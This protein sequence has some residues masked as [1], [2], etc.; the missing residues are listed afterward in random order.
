MKRVLLHIAFWFVYL[1]QDVVLV[2]LVDASMLSPLPEKERII[3]AIRSCLIILLPK[4]LFTYFMLYVVLRKIGKDN[5]QTRKHIIYSII[6]LIA[7]LFLYRTMVRY[8]TY[9]VVYNWSK[10]LPTYFDGVGFLVALMDIGFASGAAIVIKLIRL[11]LAAKERERNLTKEKLEAE[12]KY[13]R[14]QTNPHFLFNTLNNIYALTRKKSDEAPEAVMKL[15]KLLRFMLYESRK[16]FIKIGDEMKMLDNYIELEKIR[17]NGRLTINFFREI[18]DENEQI[19]PLLLLPFVENYFKHGASE[20]RF[21]SYIHIDMRLQN[22]VLNFNV[23]NTKELRENNS[24]ESIGLNNVRRQLELMYKDYDMNVQ[25]EDSVF[26]V[27][28][29]INLKSH[30]KI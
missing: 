1:F 14:N 8:F 17:Y 5:S 27:S 4:L 23:E 16:A 29:K 26:K 28:L 9:P 22:S 24:N 6:A 12:L 11:Q 25:N 15:S 2:F 13:L 7:S 19:S 30:A 3:I 20:N 10:N 18:D 21:K